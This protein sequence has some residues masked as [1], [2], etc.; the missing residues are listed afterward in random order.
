MQKFGARVLNETEARQAF[1]RHKQAIRD[2]AR[3]H[4]EK[5]WVDEEGRVFLTTHF[6]TLTVTFKGQA[7]ND[8]QV[9]NANRVLTEIIG[10]DAGE[11]VVEWEPYVVGEGRSAVLRLKDPVINREV[12]SSVSED[13]LS[14]PNFLLISLARVWGA[15]LSARSR[16]LTLKSG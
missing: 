14:D 7:A 9:A 6:T 12:M 13:V 16:F 1:D 4:I 15:L 2:L 5:G 3:S 8:A 10:P 11:V